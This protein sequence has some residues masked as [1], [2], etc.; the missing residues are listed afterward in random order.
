VDTEPPNTGFAALTASSARVLLVS[1]ALFFG[2]AMFSLTTHAEKTFREEVLEGLKSSFATPWH[3]LLD[4]K[5]DSEWRNL[6]DGVTVSLS[7]SFPLSRSAFTE[8]DGLDSQGTRSARNQTVNLGLS[9]NP[10][11]YWFFNANFSGYINSDLQAAWNPDFTYTFGYNDWHPWTLSLVYANY[12][13]NRLNPDRSAGETHTNFDQGSWTLGWKTPPPESIQRIFRIHRTSRLGCNVGLSLTPK[14]LDLESLSEKSWKKVFRY[15][16]KYSIYKNWY[17]NF[18]GAH[19]LDKRQKQP[20]DPDF[21]WGF[22]YFDWR[23]GKISI[24]YNNYA[25]NR[26]PWRKDRDF[27]TRLKD[28]SISI[29]WKWSF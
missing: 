24:Q 8:T 27:T 13:G 21:T 17:V 10:L 5:H 28:G 7:S 1:V 26:F 19:Y 11:S 3:E 6:F 25:A 2:T 20:W 23:P 15:G 22:G 18:N 14:Y 16:C 12:G 29:S 9:Y 4:K